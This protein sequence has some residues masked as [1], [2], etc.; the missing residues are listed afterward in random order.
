MYI[1]EIKMITGD[2]N[3]NIDTEYTPNVYIKN[4]KRII[5]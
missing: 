3:S 4:G 5:M 2:G 1:T